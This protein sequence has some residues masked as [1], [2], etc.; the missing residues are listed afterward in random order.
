MSG[1]R[2]IHAGD[3]HLDSPLDQ[4]RSLDKAAADA[5]ALATRMSLQR[6]VDLAIER[7]VAALIIAG[8][9]F[10]GPVK[11]ASAALWVDGQLKRLARNGIDVVLIRGNHDALSG[12]GKA[13][14]WSQGIV[15]LGSAAP[16]THLIDRVGLAVHGQSFGARAIAEDLAAGYP[17]RMD[18][19]FNVGVLHTSLGGSA[20]HERYAPTSLSVLESLGYQYWA[21]GHI[22]K[23][24]E[25]SLG[26]NCWI[27]Y[28]GNSQGR[29]VRESGPKGCYLAHVEAGALSMCEFVA[30]DS[31][32]WHEAIID[33]SEVNRM[34]DLDDLLFEQ[35]RKLVDA[36]DARHLAVRTTFVGASRLHAE[37]SDPFVVERLTAALAARLHDLSCV[38]LESVKIGTVSPRTDVPLAGCELPLQCLSEVITDVRCN[39]GQQ[40]QMLKSLDELS[41]KVRGELEP[42]GWELWREASRL[43]EFE[44]LLQRAE[45]LLRA[46]IC[47]GGDV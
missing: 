43:P 29:H 39:S 38:W 3:V 25:V 34:T 42:I 30:T 16:E 4:L 2:F 19:Y 14:R 20:A 21:L 27:G 5:V 47:N 35:A 9:L 22:H 33:V 28:C 36:A 1:F 13:I 46:R 18:G 7:E 8:D 12:A 32:R 41:R 10:D 6:I 45:D 15:E 17:R 40:T 44:R 24:T 23:R 26:S 31:V 37:L 11:D